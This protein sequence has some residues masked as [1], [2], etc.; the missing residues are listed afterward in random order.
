[1]YLVLKN[2]S[3]VHIPISSLKTIQFWNRQR[4][5]GEEDLHH[6]GRMDWRLGHYCGE[7]QANGRFSH[8]APILSESAVRYHQPIRYYN[9]SSITL[10]QLLKR[11]IFC[12]SLRYWGYHQMWT[13]VFLHC[14]HGRRQ[15]RGGQIGRNHQQRI[16]GTH[17]GKFFMR[18]L[19]SFGSFSPQ[20]SLVYYLIRYISGVFKHSLL[21]NHESA[22]E[23]PVHTF[24]YLQ[25]WP[26]FAAYT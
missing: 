22:F 17:L 19:F 12:Y 14:L 15:A 6:H 13:Q 26:R 25:Q 2:V 23:T 5:T 18:S 8:V 11:T 4:A 16:W 20:K 7:G 1:M 10:P 3:A 21:E 9:F 24:Y